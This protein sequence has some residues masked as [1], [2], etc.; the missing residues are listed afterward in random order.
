VSDVFHLSCRLECREAV[1]IHENTLADHL[2]Y[3]AVEAVNN[4]IK[5]G[6]AKNIVI[7]LGERNRGGILMV[8]DDGAGFETV[9]GTRVGLGLS[10][11]EYRAKM[12][13]GSMEMQSI[14]GEG[15]VVTCMFPLRKA[16]G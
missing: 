5:H 13:G 3:I 7:R 1:P 2:Y 11:M 8:E 10:I 9:S 16:H 15:T 6:R 4:A 14:P 12:V